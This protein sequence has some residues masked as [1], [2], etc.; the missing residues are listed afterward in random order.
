MGK[1]K[2]EGQL[3]NPIKSEDGKILTTNSN[4]S[5][6]LDVLPENLEHLKKVSSQFVQQILQSGSYEERAEAALALGYVN[7]SIAVPYLQEALNS[8]KMIKPI[9]IKGLERIGDK[10]AV[11]ALITIVNEK[12]E[13]ETASLAKFSLSVIEN[14]KSSSSE[15][16]QTIKQFLRSKL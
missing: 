3:V 13:P 11:Q 6:I 2:I 14:K 8:N 10:N 7:D 4:F 1:Y 12:S 5:V 15:I 16:K 9:V